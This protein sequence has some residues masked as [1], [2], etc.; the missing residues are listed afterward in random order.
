MFP[1]VFIHP[2]PS[3]AAAARPSGN[4]Q[5]LAYSSTYHTSYLSLCTEHNYCSSDQYLKGC[6]MTST[7]PRAFNMGSCTSCRSTSCKQWQY[8]K[9]CGGVAAGTCT[10]CTASNSVWTADQPFP[11]CPAGTYLTGCPG[12]CK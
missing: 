8:L 9:G 3:P 12:E 5:Q 6:G 7:G 1:P 10:N 11:A 4:I 2:G